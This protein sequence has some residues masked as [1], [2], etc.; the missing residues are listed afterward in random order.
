M[1]GKKSKIA[2]N[3]FIGL[4]I[5]GAGALS[6]FYI[7]KDREEKSGLTDT[8]IDGQIADIPGTNLNSLQLVSLV[9]RLKKM[10][11]KTGIVDAEDFKKL[12]DFTILILE[13][14]K[15]VINPFRTGDL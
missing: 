7:T 1:A 4:A 14:P 10:K 9:E 5:V 13:R 2:I 3:V 6:Y 8:S 11:L 15:G 12:E